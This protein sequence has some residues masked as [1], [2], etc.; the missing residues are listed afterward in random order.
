MSAI[1]SVQ[2]GSITLSA[3]TTTANLIIT[4]VNAA[5]AYIELDGS[6]YD[7]TGYTQT[8]V[9]LA[10]QSARGRVWLA[11]GSVV[12]AARGTAQGDLTLYF[13]VVEFN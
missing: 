11:S 4:S 13:T 1:A 12:S 10:L 5:K 3:G 8:D 7:P 6:Y 2:S 9:P